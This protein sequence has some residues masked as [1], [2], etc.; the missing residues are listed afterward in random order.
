MTGIKRSMCPKCNGKITVSELCQYTL[1][2]KVRQNGQVSKKYTKF[3]CGTIDC[4]IAF[5]ESCD[6]SWE[7]D[8]FSINAG[9]FIDEK[10]LDD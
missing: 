10:Y 7:Q 6:A 9:Y 8:D 4:S 1:D 3:D 5:C 2:F